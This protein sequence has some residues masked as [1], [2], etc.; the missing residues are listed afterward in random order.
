MCNSDPWLGPLFVQQGAF[1]ML[2][3]ALLSSNTFVGVKAAFAVAVMAS[4]PQNADEFDRSD[5]RCVMTDMLRAVVPGRVAGK[6]IFEVFVDAF[7]RLLEK[8]SKPILQLAALHF[9]TM[10]FMGPIRPMNEPIVRSASVVAAIRNGATGT[11]PF[12]YNASAFL[13]EEIGESVPYY[14]EAGRQNE[15]GA[16]PTQ[17]MRWTIDDVC[18]WVGLTPFKSYRT[19]FRDSFVSGKLLLTFNEQHLVDMGIT[20]RIH[21]LAILHAID[22]LRQLM[23]NPEAPVCFARPGSR[24]MSRAGSRS[25]SPDRCGSGKKKFE[26][27]A[28]LDEEPEVAYD[29]FISYRRIGGADFAQLLKIQLVAAGFKVFLDA[30]SLGTGKFSDEL[31][32]SLQGSKNVLLVWTKGCMDRFLDDKDPGNRDFVRMEYAQSLRLGKH[33]VPVFKEDFVF[34]EPDSMP[35]DCRGVLTLNAIKFVSDYREASF[36]KI[37]SALHK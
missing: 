6:S 18:H 9:C 10:K 36:N 14:R 23:L 8:D 24:F 13:L 29:V 11:D 27:L 3:P 1:T 26:V 16:D 21:R 22:D 37:K 31:K 7:T 5:I 28:V 2:Q 33:I 12:V 15:I 34:P 32:L 20:H 17:A 25:G 19:F 4:H 30:D 35:D